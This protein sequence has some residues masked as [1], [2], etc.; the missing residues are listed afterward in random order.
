M[1]SRNLKMSTDTKFSRSNSIC[2]WHTSCSNQEFRQSTQSRRL[3]MKTSMRSW[4]H[5]QASRALVPVQKTSNTAARSQN[6]E[7]RP[8]VCNLDSI[9][10]NC[11]IQK[12]CK[13][14][15]PHPWRILQNN[16][17]FYQN[18]WSFDIEKASNKL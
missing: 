2:W 10:S 15:P 11:T 8:I 17:R 5:I 13:S 16:L 4:K 14:S 6:H 9:F 3:K 1:F 12:T 7:M 18:V